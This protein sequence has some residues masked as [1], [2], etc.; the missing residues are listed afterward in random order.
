[1]QLGH[2]GPAKSRI[3]NVGILGTFQKNRPETA[4]EW[5]QDRLFTTTGV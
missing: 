3:T 1:M 4:F 2:E 5:G